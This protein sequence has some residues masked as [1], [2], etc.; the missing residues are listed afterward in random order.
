MIDKAYNEANL[1]WSFTRVAQNRGAAGVDRV[2]IDD[3]SKGLSPRLKRLTKTLADGRYRPHDVRR[4]WIDKPGS[5]E[6][7]PL[8]HFLT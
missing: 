5:K 8:G 2:T 7:R 1:F 6:K 3:F 4:V